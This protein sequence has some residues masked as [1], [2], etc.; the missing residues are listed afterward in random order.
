MNVWA[1]SEHNLYYQMFVLLLSM[2]KGFRGDLAIIAALL[3]F[4]QLKMLTTSI[5]KL[6]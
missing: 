3:F 5:H 6:I 4:Q 1:H 2:L